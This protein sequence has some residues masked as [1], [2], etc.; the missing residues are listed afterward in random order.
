[1][2]DGPSA[3]GARAAGEAALVVVFEPSGATV[4][5]DASCHSLLGFCEQAGFAPSFSCRA[6]V[7]GTCV[8]TLLA[9]EV[10][11]FE[12]PLDAPPEDEVLLCCARPVTSIRLQL[13]QSG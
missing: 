1:M 2:P 3:A 8:T 7:C 11:Y 12:P 6:G 5:W 13:R 4:A 10:S 9:G